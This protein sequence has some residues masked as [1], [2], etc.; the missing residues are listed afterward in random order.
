M[1]VFVLGIV[2]GMMRL[3]VR[4]R[5]VVHRFAVAMFV[6]MDDDLAAAAAF[7][8]VVG[9]DQSGA[10][11]FRAFPVFAG[12]DFGPHTYLLSPSDPNPSADERH[13][14]T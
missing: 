14:K 11:A 2:V 9:A 8:A 4:V 6:G 12:E 3:G 13:F 10:P 7:A 1:G 5:M